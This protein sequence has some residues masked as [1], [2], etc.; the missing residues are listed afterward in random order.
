MI[1]GVPKG[2]EGVFRFRTGGAGDARM[3]PL[4]EVIPSDAFA[5]QK[6]AAFTAAAAIKYWG[7]IR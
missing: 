1:R 3:T 5:W 7:D 2:C 6:S 4:N